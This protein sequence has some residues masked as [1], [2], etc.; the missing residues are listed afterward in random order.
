MR[1]NFRDLLIALLVV[2]IVV[3]YIIHPFISE[4]K[5]GNIIAI[6]CFALLSI[7]AIILHH[8]YR[9]H[10]QK[11]VSSSLW[12]LSVCVVLLLLTFVVSVVLAGISSP[13]DPREERTGTTNSKVREA[14]RETSQVEH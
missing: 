7:I 2:I 3:E 10:M 9:V 8:F 5:N 12:I 13:R 11:K 4:A 6:D 1:N 14:A